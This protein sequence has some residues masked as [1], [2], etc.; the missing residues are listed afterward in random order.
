MK[1]APFGKSCARSICLCIPLVFGG[2]VAK[3]EDVPQFRSDIIMQVPLGKVE[4]RNFALRATITTM[5][6]FANIP[7]HVHE[8]GGIRYVLEGALRSIGK[9]AGPKRS[10]RGP[11]TSR[12]PARTIH[13][14]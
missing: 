5:Q 11:H 1:N 12:G 6:P 9:P 3:A 8:F 13:L 2:S 10:R 4:S 14:G 7:P